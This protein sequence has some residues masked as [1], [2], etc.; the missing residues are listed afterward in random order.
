MG[1]LY[2]D[3]DDDDDDDTLRVMTAE[4]FW[5]SWTQMLKGKCSMELVAPS[6]PSRRNKQ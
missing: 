1:G 3:D 5:F 2:D 6:M 4:I